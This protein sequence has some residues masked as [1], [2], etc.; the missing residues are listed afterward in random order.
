MIKAIK[1]NKI[2]AYIAFT[3]C[4]ILIFIRCSNENPYGKVSIKQPVTLSLNWNDL[5]PNST[6]PDSIC[7]LFYSTSSKQVYK[8]ASYTNELQASL[9]PGDYQVLVFNYNVST[10]QFQYME[11]YETAEVALVHKTKAEHIMPEPDLFYGTSIDNFTVDKNQGAIQEIKPKK[12]V[13]NIS[14]KIA[15]DKIADIVMCEGTISGVSSALNLSKSTSVPLAPC[16]TTPI[17]TVCTDKG[18]EGNV[19]ILGIQPRNEHQP[20]VQNIVTLNFTLS[21]GT[22]T[23]AETDLTKQ[24][25]QTGEKDVEITIETHIDPDGNISL[26]ASVSVWEEDGN[27]NVEIH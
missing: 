5:P 22:T 27:T 19:F 23:T 20:D 17:T 12:L 10:L 15:V 1:R 21:D 18:I 25:Q 9:P 8:F 2:L 11:K 24:L 3:F 14:F 4:I 6:P 16:C 7:F 13:Q 26:T